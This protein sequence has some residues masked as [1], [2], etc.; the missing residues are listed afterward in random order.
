MSRDA[1]TQL[2]I[3]ENGSRRELHPI[4]REEATR[5]ATEAMLHSTPLATSLHQLLKLKSPTNGV[6]F[7]STYVTMVAAWMKASRAPVVMGI[8]A[9]WECTSERGAFAHD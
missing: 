2:R 3:I 6:S 1:T 8:S 7:A 9:S 5:I 4:V